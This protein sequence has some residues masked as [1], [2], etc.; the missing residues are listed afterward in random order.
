MKLNEIGITQEQ[1]LIFF[2]STKESITAL[3]KDGEFRSKT[4]PSLRILAHKGYVYVWEC[5]E[6]Q[7][8]RI[9][10]MLVDGFRCMPSRDGVNKAYLEIHANGGDSE[11][12]NPDSFEI[13]LPKNV[14]SFLLDSFKPEFLNNDIY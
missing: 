5:D 4:Y 7:C 1:I 9:Q 14:I 13:D 6:N 2:N 3:N 8:I 11:I 10:N 12:A